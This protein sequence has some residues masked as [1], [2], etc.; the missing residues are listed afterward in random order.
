MSYVFALVD[1]LLVL[2][3][4]LLAATIYPM[5]RYGL[6]L[7]EPYPVLKIMLVVAV[8]ELTYYYMDLM[9]LKVLRQRIRM[10]LQLLK[11]LGIYSLALVVIYFMFSNIAMSHR[12]LFAS[13][14]FIF[15]LTFLWR[16]LYPLIALNGFFRERVLIVGTGELARKIYKEIED[17][18]TDTYEIVGFVDEKGARVGEEIPL[19]D[20]R[21]LQANLFHMQ[22]LPH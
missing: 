16:L 8:V 4:V 19:D 12:T 13:L 7:A 3:A 5:G 6:F 15:G 1:G 21:R 11:S 2:A 10:F 9:D 20:H 22:N 18:G 14:A 17:H